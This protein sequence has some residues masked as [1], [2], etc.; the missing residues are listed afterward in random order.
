MNEVDHFS[1]DSEESIPFHPSWRLHPMLNSYAACI[2]LQQ[3]VYWQKKMMLKGRTE[4]YK[5]RAPC[6]HAMYSTGDS[7]TEELG[8]SRDE[9]DAALKKIA[10][11][12]TKSN[13]PDPDA[14]IWY[15]TDTNR[16]T[17]Y[18]VNFPAYNRLKT[19]IYE[20]RE[21]RDRKV[22]ESS[23]TKVDNSCLPSLFSSETNSRDYQQEIVAPAKSGPD[24]AAELAELHLAICT[25]L[26][27]Q[28]LTTDPN[29]RRRPESLAAEIRKL[30]PA[31][32][33]ALRTAL[34]WAESQ[35]YWQRELMKHATWRTARYIE[36]VNQ[37]ATGGNFRPPREFVNKLLTPPSG[38]LYDPAELN[39]RADG[40]LIF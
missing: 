29:R 32:L 37:H 31:T 11:K 8:M 36:L 25:R 34:Q 15:R 24:E 38:S 1:S 20:L 4:F 21:S 19:E 16:V 10:K 35:P 12:F 27:G 17:W 22:A 5:F 33:S 7:W 26:E 13:P 2:L 40:S 18:Q 6:D 3:M 9:L 14:V 30:P 28:G 23:R 39:L